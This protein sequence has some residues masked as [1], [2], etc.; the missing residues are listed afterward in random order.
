M[1]KG[2]ESRENPEALNLPGSQGPAM[3]VV[4]KLYLISTTEYNG[5]ISVA[6]VRAV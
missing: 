6:S 5:K 1:C 4:G 3:S 2:A